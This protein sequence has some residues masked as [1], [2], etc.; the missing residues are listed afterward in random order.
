VWHTLLGVIRDSDG[1]SASFQN[2]Q[3]DLPDQGLVLVECRGGVEA[4]ANLVSASWASHN[5]CLPVGYSWLPSEV[6][7]KQVCRPGQPQFSENPPEIEK[8]P[9]NQGFLQEN[10]FT[11]R[12]LNFPGGLCNRLPRAR[13][14][15]RKAT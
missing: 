1:A 15:D 11:D 2:A 13:A 14:S 3:V 7:N 4:G 10:S 5:S 9:G 8:T 12:S 6:N